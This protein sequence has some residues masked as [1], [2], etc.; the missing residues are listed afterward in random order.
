[1]P[2]RGPGGVVDRLRQGQDRQV[3]IPGA[4]AVHVDLLLVTLAGQHE[5]A[6]EPGRGPRYDLVRVG[7][8]EGQLDRLAHVRAVGGGGAGLAVEQ[9][10]EERHVRSGVQGHRVHRRVGRVRRGRPGRPGRRRADQHQAVV[11]GDGVG[12]AVVRQRPAVRVVRDLAVPRGDAVQAGVRVFV[13]G[14]DDLAGVRV[15]GQPVALAP[16]VPLVDHRAVR[17]ELDDRAVTVPVRAGL[18]LR[19]HPVLETGEQV[20]ADHGDVVGQGQRF[21]VLLAGS[22]LGVPVVQALAGQ[23]LAHVVRRRAGMG[24]RRKGEDHHPQ[25]QRRH[26]ADRRHH[27]HDAPC[28]RAPSDFAHSRPPS[29]LIVSTFSGNPERVGS[30]T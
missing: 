15:S 5:I 27:L 7:V 1:M 29:C 13:D 10:P 12:A 24:A 19:P 8:G 2:G 14:G 26:R 25:H 22:G 17:R 4:G 11:E 6:A 20:P 16:D 30:V 3:L 21:A 9:G 18:P 23:D 28:D